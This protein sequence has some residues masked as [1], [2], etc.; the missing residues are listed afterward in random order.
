MN[1]DEFHLERQEARI[2]EEYQCAACPAIIDGYEAIDPFVIEDD[3]Y[4]IVCASDLVNLRFHGYIDKV[5]LKTDKMVW[6]N[7][8]KIYDLINFGKG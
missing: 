6:D 4:C 1:S 3:V 2:E 5:A 8:Y 7:Y